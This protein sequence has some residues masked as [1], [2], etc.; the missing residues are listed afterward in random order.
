MLMVGGIGYD[1]PQR[2]KEEF[3]DMWMFAGR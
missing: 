2:L 1:V 3:A